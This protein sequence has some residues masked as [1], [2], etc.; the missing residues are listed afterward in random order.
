MQGSQDICHGK[1]HAI[2]GV[3]QR[4]TVNVT[5]RRTGEADLLKSAGDWNGRSWLLA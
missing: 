4:E 2:Y 5:G 1:M 3:G